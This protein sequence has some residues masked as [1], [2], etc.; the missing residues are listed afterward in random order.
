MHCAE[1]ALVMRQSLMQRL[2]PYRRSII[3][4]VHLPLIA[5]GARDLA[6]EAPADARAARFHY[7]SGLCGRAAAPPDPARSPRPAERRGADRRRPRPARADAARRVGGG[8][9]GPAERAGGPLP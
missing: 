6:P 8:W 9:H 7:W 2:Y 4:G 1:R 3:P 5:L